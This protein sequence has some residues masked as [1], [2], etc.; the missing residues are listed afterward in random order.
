MLWSP[1]RQKMEIAMESSEAKITG[2]LQN[3]DDEIF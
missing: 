2:K 1:E 3:H